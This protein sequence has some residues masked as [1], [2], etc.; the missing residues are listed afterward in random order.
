MGSSIVHSKPSRTFFSS[1]SASSS[2]ILPSVVE[3]WFTNAKG[4]RTTQKK[5]RIAFISKFFAIFEPH[6]LLL[7]GVMKYLPRSEFEVIALPVARTD[8]KALSPGVAEA[9]DQ[10]VPV[11]IL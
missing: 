2:L 1:S 4:N 9:V 6:G 8:P 5:K 10:I 3:D 7:D 11:I